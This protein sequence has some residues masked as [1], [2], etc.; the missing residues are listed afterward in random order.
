VAS[1]ASYEVTL[2]LMAPVIGGA[3][4]VV[5]DVVAEGALIFEDLDVRA[6]AGGPYRALVRTFSVEVS[7]GRLDVQFTSVNTAAVVSAIAVVRGPAS[8]SSSLND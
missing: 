1:A 2:Y 7:D 3:G 4:N 8:T 5:M 6:Q